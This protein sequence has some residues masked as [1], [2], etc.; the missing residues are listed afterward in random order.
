MMLTNQ[1]FRVFVS[2]TFSDLKA[3]RDAL[4]RFVF[5]KLRELCRLHGAHFQAI[6]LR[7]GVSDEA[8]HMQ[9]TM[10]ICLEEIARC[11]RTTPRP[12][13][14]ILLGDRYGWRPVPGE[15]LD[16]DFE[17]ICDQL[18]ERARPGQLAL[19]DKAYDRD[20]NA[21]PPVRWLKPPAEKHSDPKVREKSEEAL[22][23][24]FQEACV[25]LSLD[26]AEILKF[27]ASATE[28]EIDRGVML[29]E[30]T[31]K[32]VHAFIRSIRNLEAVPRAE[33]FQD[34]EVSAGLRSKRLKQQLRRCL[35]Q[36]IST[37]IWWIGQATGSRPITSAPSL[38]RTK[39]ARYRRK[40]QLRHTHPSRTSAR[41]STT[42]SPE[43]SGAS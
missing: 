10:S 37:N 8:A 3:E 18:K 14:V 36:L 38:M 12:N 24:I 30:G 40:A 22:L 21:L 35:P 4:Q 23:A 27:G 5:P 34:C 32:D 41:S 42:L 43:L 20:D 6:D 19:L 26:E 25:G 28:Q 7:W 33:A 13:F 9:Q 39:G 1:T 2:S 11:Q 29:N 17:K 15:I 31:A 16:R